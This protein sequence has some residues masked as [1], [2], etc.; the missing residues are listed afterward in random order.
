MVCMKIVSR[1]ASA[2]APNQLLLNKASGCGSII[3]MAVSPDD[4][5]ASPAQN[6]KKKKKNKYATFSKADKIEKDPLE[7]MIEESEEKVKAIKTEAATKKI[8]VVPVSPEA[9]K[10]LEFPNNKDIDPYDPTTFGYVE[11]GTVQG[12]HGVHGWVKVQGCTD[13][14]ERLT[15]PGMPLHFKPFRKRAPRKITLAAGK[16][17]GVDSFL[18]QFQGVYNRTEAGKLKGASIYY[19]TQQ[20]KVV[21]EDDLIVSDLVGLEVYTA[22]EEILVGTVQG[23]VLAEEMCAVPGLG[24][25]MLE[26]AIQKPKNDVPTGRP[27]PDDLILIPFVPEIVPKVDL[28]ER[29]IVVDPPAGLLDLTYIRE[30]RVVLKG[31]LPPAKTS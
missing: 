22:E 10:R 9:N 18:V 5:F 1:D 3:R 4:L 31:L 7:Q 8:K 6:K 16:E 27:V 20:D 29:K 12:A 17:T 23:I 13:F 21:Q 15:K 19:A 28:E 24:Q 30:E 26:V 11:I 25:D 2:F 14:P